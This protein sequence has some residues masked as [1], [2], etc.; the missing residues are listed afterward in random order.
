MWNKKE[1]KRKPY[2]EILKW[3]VEDQL[4]GTIKEERA[5]GNERLCSAFCSAEW[6]LNMMAVRENWWA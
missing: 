2:D 3:E 1:Q 6:N 4:N 5:Q